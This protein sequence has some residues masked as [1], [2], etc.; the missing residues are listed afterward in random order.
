MYEAPREFYNVDIAKPTITSSSL[1][2]DLGNIFLI[3]IATPENSFKFFADN[4][5]VF[6]KNINIKKGFDFN[7]T[8]RFVFVGIE[9]EFEAFSGFNI[10]SS[11]WNFGDETV[12]EANGKKIKHRYTE[13]GIFN[14][15]VELKRKDGTSSK[16]TFKINVGNP[17]ESVNF[18]LR[19]YSS[20]LQNIS[21]QIQILSP[22]LKESVLKNLEIDKINSSL[23]QLAKDYR[24]ASSDADYIRIIDQLLEIRVPF[25]VFA[26]EKGELPLAIG[27]N[28]I[29]AG[30][31]KEA[32]NKEGDGD[33]KEE[34]IRW[35]N[36]NYKSD[37]KF[38]TISASFEE[39]TEKLASYFELS[40]S[41]LSDKSEE[42]YLFINYP[43][44]SIKFK[45]D[46]GQKSIGE[47]S[48][49][50]IPI[51]SETK[52][53]VFVIENGISAKELG[54]Y[55]APVK[56]FAIEKKSECPE[57]NPECEAKF[58]LVWLFLG[59][60]IV[61][62][63]FFIIYLV[64]QEWYKKNYE[65]HLF[66]NPDDLYNLIN[67]IYNSRNA[68]LLDNDIRKKLRQTGWSN[69]RIS[70]AFKKL[71][72]K[73]TGMWEIPLFKESERRKVKEE[74]A[75]RQGTNARFIKQ[76]GF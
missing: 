12:E 22:A 44:E 23:Q 39:G 55:L 33:N 70:Y 35:Y 17:K 8:P 67:F 27:F 45:Q 40:V 75:K 74:I 49:A 72:G 63:L 36:Q 50:Y 9:T 31:F 42:G 16:K 60:G 43:F 4:S 7:V 57:G 47:G 19:T 46:Y 59:L 66:K 69:E 2:L 30:Y 56:A 18:T 64:V 51:K 53:F 26:S 25:R 76:P 6:E 5:L 28:N 38:E 54:A 24:N 11:K 58:P 62:V 34:I 65:K 13:T 37:I 71:D 20:R 68:G 48:G 52:S 1:N 14:L 3:P 15:E 10:T 73:R 41:P 32:V 61:I 21:K 29:D